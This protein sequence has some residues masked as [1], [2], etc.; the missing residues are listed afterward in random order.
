MSADHLIPAVFYGRKSDEDDGGSVEQQLTWARGAAPEESIQ[1]IKE[2][3]DQAKKGHETASRTAFHDM[4]SFC[5]QRAKKGSP[6]EAV[7]CWH[8]NRFSRADSIE[9]SWF[10]HEFRKAGVRRMFTAARG[11]VDFGRKEDRIIF[12]IEQDTTNHQ[13]VLDLAQDCTRG[14]L[15][16]ARAGRWMGGPIPHGYR[17]EMEKVTVKGKTR[18]VTARLVLGPAAEVEVVRRIFREY[19]DTAVGLWRLAQRLTTDGVPPPRGGR[20]GWTTHTVRNILTNPVYLGRL[21]WGRRAQGKFFGVVNAEITPL[22]GT[23]KSRPNDPAAYVYAPSQTHEPLVDLATWEKCQEKLARHKKGR[24]PRL[25]CY[26]LSGLVRCG[27]CEGNMVARVDRVK[28]HTYRRVLCGT[29]NRSGGAGCWFN[30]VD[31]DA[32]V[33]AVV[34]KLRTQLFSPDA[35][36]ALREEIGRQADGATAT[37][38]VLAT[39]EARL[40]QL[41][42]GVERAA[43]RVVEEEDDRLVPALRKQLK[44][45]TDEHDDLARQVEAARLS[46]QK[47]EDLEAIIKEVEAVAGRFEEALTAEDS[48]LLREVLGEVVGYVELLFSHEPMGKGKRT[49]SKFAR[50]LIYL[51]PQRW[52]E[53]TSSGSVPGR[54]WGNTCRRR[55]GR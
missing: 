21:V 6:V 51:R 28:G 32:L 42:R 20:R 29:Y 50:G 19:A 55:S 52:N 35:L 53:S 43:R 47:P 33:R 18:W 54:R 5:Q 11:W 14:R 34:G 44:A 40:A 13:Y 2:F 7:I 16:G 38:K 9:T 17:P 8:P 49:H 10:V 22:D 46:R 39:L 23:K 26:P 27:H 24:Q 31:A 1:I 45:V 36:E 15:A 37:G 3:T 48:D 41:A 25:G 12:G 30:A 4:L